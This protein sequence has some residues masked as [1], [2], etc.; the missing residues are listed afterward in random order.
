MKN[1]KIYCLIHCLIFI[2]NLLECFQAKHTLTAIDNEHYAIRQC[3]PDEQLSS[4][5][6]K[7]SYC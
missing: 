5:W 7:G 2:S 1:Y 3:L 6:N 4:Y